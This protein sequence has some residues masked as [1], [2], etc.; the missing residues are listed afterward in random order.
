MVNGKSL[1]SVDIA[2]KLL[3][4]KAKFELNNKIF[5]KWEH[6]DDP[7]TWDEI[8]ETIKKIEKYVENNDLP[9]YV[10]ID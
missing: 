10:Y 7:P 9:D 4:P 3:R 6:P 1:V 2:I 5:T 8:D